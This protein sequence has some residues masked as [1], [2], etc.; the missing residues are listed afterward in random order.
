MDDRHE[1]TLHIDLPEVIETSTRVEVRCGE[2]TAYV[3]EHGSHGSGAWA[4]WTSIGG[5]IV[6][7]GTNGYPVERALRYARAHVR[8]R[9]RLR[10]F[11]EQLSATLAVDAPGSES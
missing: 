5:S 3:Y 9:E 10:L 7:G 8:H 6:N 1:I 2:T 11:H 4:V